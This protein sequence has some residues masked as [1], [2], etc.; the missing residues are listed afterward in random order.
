MLDPKE[1]GGGGKLYCHFI[2]VYVKNG[3]QI[4]FNYYSKDG[5]KLTKQ[6]IM[7]AIDGKSLM[8]QGY[9]RIKESAKTA[10]YVYVYNKREFNVKWIDLTTLANSTEAINISSLTD[11]VS[12]VS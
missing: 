4:F 7:S 10:N 1:A 2:Q 11:T 3:G 5:T 6:T 12:L 9:V 8:C